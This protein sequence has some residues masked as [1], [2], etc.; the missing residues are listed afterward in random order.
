MKQLLTFVSVLALILT[1]CSSESSS[2]SSTTGTKLTQIIETF[3]DG[4]TET[5]NFEYNGDKILSYTWDWDSSIQEEAF[6]TYTGDLITKE[7]YFFDDNDPLEAF[8]E[9]TDYEYDTSGRLTKSTR[10]ENDSFGTTITVDNFIYNSNGTVSFTTTENSVLYATGTI[11]FNGNQPFKKVVTEDIGTIDEFT[12]T[13]ENF[14]DDKVNPFNNVTGF[15]KIEIAC[16]TYHYGFYGMPNNVIEIKQDGVSKETS[17]YTYNSNNM[18]ATE[19]YIDNDNNDNN[20]TS[21]YIY[22]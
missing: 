10:T 1:S 22:N 11:Y 15:S 17:T 9:V 12:Y 21:Q 8:S 3:N 13:E 5:I 18:P 2:S 16:P 6:F 14:Y 19:L 7:E 4:S 20:S